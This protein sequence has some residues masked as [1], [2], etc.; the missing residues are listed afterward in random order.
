MRFEKIAGAKYCWSQLFKPEGTV[1]AGVR[2]RRSGPV[3]RQ[4]HRALAREARNPSEFI[5]ISR[6]ASRGG[7]AK[8]GVCA[9]KVFLKTENGHETGPQGTDFSLDP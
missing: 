9:P 8:G 3:S 6:E 7:F 4:I 2:G 5:G 1:A